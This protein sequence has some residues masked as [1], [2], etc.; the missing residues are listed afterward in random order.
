MGLT[1]KME[2]FYPNMKSGVVTHTFLHLTLQEYLAALYWAETSPHQLVELFSRDDLFPIS[3][4]VKSGIKE[5]RM[6][7]SSGY[8]WPVLLFSGGLTKLHQVGAEFIKSKLVANFDPS[9]C[10]LLYEA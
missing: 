5:D 6:S 10:Q 4:L 3:K 1:Q 9:F 7:S 8:H 2:E